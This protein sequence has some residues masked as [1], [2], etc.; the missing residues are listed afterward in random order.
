[1]NGVKALLEVLRPG[2][3]HWKRAALSVLLGVATLGA[4]LGLLASSGYL[5]S[6]AALRP[7]ILTLTTVIVAVRF[8]GIV[9]AI[10]RYLERLVSHDA[11]FRMIT[12]LRV[13]MY[14]RVAPLAPGRIG[15]FRSG[16]LLSRFVAD[17]DSLQHV[18]VRGVSPM[19]VAV[20]AV[21]TAV[22]VSALTLPGAA[23]VLALALLLAAIGI[24]LLGR[25]VA[26]TA[27]RRRSPAQGTLTA[28]LVELF[29]GAPELVLYGGAHE[30][31]RRVR[32]A[33]G[34]LARLARRDAVTAGLTGGLGT[35]AAAATVVLVVSVGAVAVHDGSLD[36]I[37]LAVL[38]FLTLA[39]FEAVTPLPT[40]GQQLTAGA[41]V[42]ERID[43]VVSSDVPARDPVRPRPAERL[44][45]LTI[46]SARVRYRP[47]GPWVLDG[48]D[49]EVRPGKRLAL[50]G[51]SGSGK[52]TVARVLV[53]FCELD[54]GRAALNGHDLRD[55]RQ[56][57]I[58][59]QVVLGSE[60]AHLFATSIS[61]NIRLAKPEASDA[62]IFRAVER[63]GASQWVSSL[64]EGLDT[65]VGEEGALV[66]GGQRQRI[67]LAR[68]LL[69]EARIV[70][71]DEP[72]AH[73]DVEAAAMFV[74]DLVDAT[75][76]V[77]LLMITHNLRSLGRFDE[78]LVL[79]GGRIV[80]RGTER[81][82]L[83]R[84]GVYSALA[85]EQS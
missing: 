1:M 56:A 85:A 62:E 77:G 14:E 28:E 39:S 29:R 67:A 2:R 24:P 74:E 82:L 10:C 53:R 22:L 83:E 76:D 69:A 42:A 5:I 18:F 44:V 20:G 19:L 78:I 46:E 13:R 72:T 70:I 12:Q 81:E 43:E 6:K 58:R 32:A 40:A 34:E 8:F 16:D 59:R 38:A 23:V 45:S 55:Y 17:V 37:Y 27:I 7:E 71:L 47:D 65:F 64:P 36:G 52:S 73:L 9:R 79:D 63:A 57:D 61:E 35:F 33:D 48:L 21:G 60:E 68:V 51:A 41:A 54:E 75:E 50:V 49:L 26:R 15:E 30:H 31:Q 84:G 4:G 25:A 80:E 3:A 11:A 66:S